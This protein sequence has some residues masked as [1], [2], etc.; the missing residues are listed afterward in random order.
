MRLAGL[1]LIGALVL[2][3]LGCGGGGRGANEFRFA[4]NPLVRDTF[5]AD[6]AAMVYRGRLYLYTGHDQ[7]GRDARSFVM[8][9]WRC[10]STAD[11]VNWRFEGTPLRATTFAW[12]SGGA[13]ASHVVER[14]GRFYFF[15]PV[16]C[17]DGSGFAIGVAVADRPEGPFV[18]AIGRPLVRNDMTPTANRMLHDDID[19]AVVFDEGGQAWLVWGNTHCYLMPLKPSLTEP[20]GEIRR[21]ELPMF[22]EAPWIH[23]YNGRYYLSY[24]HR[25][26]ETIAYATSERVT[27]PY[28]FEGIIHGELPNC[29]TNHQAIVE[30]RGKWWFFYHTAAVSGFEFQRSV[31]VERLEHDRQGRI[32]PIGRTLKENVRG[33]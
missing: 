21:L 28:R 2:G 14:G 19:P 13:F 23:R 26:P 3:V 33:E 4:G 12:A 6:P 8:D 32:R 1:I 11:M 30:F 22:T 17:R 10:Y 15:A 24:A 20:A 29:P 16:W 7:A 27:G 18:D 31:S 5:T 25:F 9:E